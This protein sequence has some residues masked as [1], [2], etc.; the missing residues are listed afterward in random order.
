MKEEFNA[1]K[2]KLADAENLVEAQRKEL[3]AEKTNGIA[4]IHEVCSIPI[5]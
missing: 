5:A 3:D 2:A 1:A 4:R